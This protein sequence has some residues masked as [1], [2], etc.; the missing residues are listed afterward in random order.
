MY[1]VSAPLGGGVGLGG[2]PLGGGVGLGGGLAGFAPVG[3]ARD[4]KEGAPSPAQLENY[5]LFV[6]VLRTW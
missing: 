1:I 6:K 5:K 2:T 3:A 4:P